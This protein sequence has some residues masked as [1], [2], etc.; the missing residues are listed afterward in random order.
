MSEISSIFEKN[1]SMKRTT[2]AL[3]TFI[4]GILVVPQYSCETEDLIGTFNATSGSENW[5][6]VAPG[7]VKTGNRF[8]ITGVTSTKSIVLNTN[9]ISVGSYTMDVFSGNI[10]P[11]VYTPDLSTPQT[12]YVGTAGSIV[13][14][15]VSSNRLSGSFNVTATNS[16]SQSMTVTGN[17]TN[18]LYSF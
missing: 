1:Y 9:G 18:V 8:T 13:L 3:M 15:S 5:S 17:F 10:Q 4:L 14:S 7:A 16:Q 2:I 12:A 11:F 6:A